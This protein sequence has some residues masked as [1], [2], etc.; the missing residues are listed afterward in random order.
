MPRSLLSRSV[1]LRAVATVAALAATVPAGGAR[2]ETIP[3][4]PCAGK[5]APS[6]TGGG[7]DV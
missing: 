2:A 7:D 4:V 3:A 1:T 5:K 6:K